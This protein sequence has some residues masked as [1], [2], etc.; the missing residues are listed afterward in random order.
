MSMAIITQ[1]EAN[2]VNGGSIQG[3]IS[4]TDSTAAA[5]TWY[6]RRLTTL[7]S[8]PDGIITTFTA[9][10]S[11]ANTTSFGSFE[12]AP[13]IYRITA[14]LTY[15][16]DT[17]TTS[18]SFAAALWNHTDSVFEKYNGGSDYIVSTIGLGSS[19]NTFSGPNITLVMEAE[20]EV[21]G[22][23]KT[24]YIM[25]QASDATA[26]KNKNCCG[27]GGPLTSTTTGGINSAA[28]PF[29]YAFLKILKVS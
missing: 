19:V 2:T 27:T 26:A 7:L 1:R 20:W 6:A 12:L 14:Y 24:F 22:F 23:N 28:I 16:N 21:L 13:G 25:Q 10:G 5:V 4:G 3:Y 8:D 11:G 15:R 18:E 9:A 17:T 29:V